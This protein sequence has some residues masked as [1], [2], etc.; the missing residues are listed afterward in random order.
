MG[1]PDG[2]F[3]TTIWSEIEAIRTHN[4]TYSI[5]MLEK[6]LVK[7]WKPVYCYLRRKGFD[8][9]SAK[10]LTQ[11]FF[12]EV[13]LGRDLIQR[14]ESNRGRFR[15]FLLT[16]LDRYVISVHCQ[17]TAKKRHP[18]S[19]IVSLES[20]QLGNLEE[21]QGQASPEQ[22]FQYAWAANLLDQV[23]VK[24]RKQCYVTGKGV[25]W[26]I[27]RERILTPIFENTQPLSFENICTKYDV[28]SETIASNMIVTV[29]RVFRRAL[30]KLLRELVTSEDQVEN[31]IG[32]LFTILSKSS[33]R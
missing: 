16:A 23:L 25:H 13:V 24:T 22:I 12:H 14:S 15:T 8:N 6:L 19:K 30:E 5:Q 21:S 28:T 17:H 27:F 33:A 3:R 20:G 2:I 11:G 4:E 9:E 31:E 18:I 26:E 32:E 10:D 1:G 29:K 7:Y